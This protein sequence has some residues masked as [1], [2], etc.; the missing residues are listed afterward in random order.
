MVEIYSLWSLMRE[1][2]PFALI[3]PRSTNNHE[4]KTENVQ[5]KIKI[6]SD[7]IK[8]VGFGVKATNIQKAITQTVS[9]RVQTKVVITP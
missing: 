4:T 1:Y 3:K 8:Y 2:K 7:K 9:K 6:A 5:K